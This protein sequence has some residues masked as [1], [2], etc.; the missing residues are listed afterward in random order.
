LSKLLLSTKNQGKIAELTDLLADVSVELLVPQDIGLEILVEEAG[1][2]YAENAG[3]K[4]A[5]Y[6]R[7]SG[8]LAL[9]DDSGLEVDLLDG[10]PGV[11]SARFAPQ[12]GATDS[13]RR[14]YLLERLKGFPQPWTA[15]FR[16]II[17]IGTPGGQ[18]FFSE[19]V[20]PGQ[21]L[22]QERGQ[23]GF[24][25][26]RL[27]LLPEQGLSMAELSMEQKNYLSHRARALLAAKPILL[28]L[29]SRYP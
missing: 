8:L 21:V 10:Q 5:E 29:L 7:S 23:F 28:N 17:A 15:R 24:G 4:A 19:G 20:C 6:A 9:A 26:D 22:P 2:T 25:Y 16:C 1:M 3:R 27:F 13:D 18:L 11:H 14:V 12:P